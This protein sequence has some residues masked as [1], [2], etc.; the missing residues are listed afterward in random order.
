[1][2]MMQL[3]MVFII[4][5]MFMCMFMFIIIIFIIRPGPRGDFHP[6]ALEAPESVVPQARFGWVGGWGRWV[7]WVGEVTTSFQQ[8]GAPLKSADGE[9]ATFAWLPGRPR[10]D[11]GYLGVSGVLHCFL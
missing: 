7:G 5:I 3:M 11:L 8:R 6:Q 4:I 9:P 1:M 10:S 2:K